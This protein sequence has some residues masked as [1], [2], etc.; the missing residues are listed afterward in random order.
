MGIVFKKLVGTYE[1]I[2][3]LKSKLS[4]EILQKLHELE[5]QCK[6]VGGMR[7]RSTKLGITT[8]FSYNIQNF[9]LV[10][11]SRRYNICL[12]FVLYE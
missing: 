7:V 10:L 12:I 11:L 3:T 2:K 1:N 8:N 5:I 4:N 6:K 9:A